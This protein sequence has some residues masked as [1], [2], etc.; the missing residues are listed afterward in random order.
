M[1]LLIVESSEKAKLI[2][3]MLG[4]AWAVEACLGHVRDLPDRELGVDLETL[5]PTYQVSERSART[6]NKLRAQAAKSDHIFLATDKDREGEAIAWH[7]AVLLGIEQPR[8][9]MYTEVTE[10]A[11]RAAIDSPRSIDMPKV[12]AQETRRVLDR[13]VGY[14]LS[15]VVSDVAQRPGLSAG[16]VQSPALCLISDRERAIADF[17]PTPHFS[18]RAHFATPGEDGENTAWFADW[19]PSIHLPPGQ[20]LCLDKALAE[21]VAENNRFTVLSSDTKRTARHAPAPFTTSVLQ[22]VA[23]NKLGFDPKETMQLAQRLYDNGL[24]TY[25]RTD[26]PHLAEEAIDAIR[27]TITGSRY[28]ALLSA[29]P[30]QYKAKT[31]AEE[32]H[33]AIRPTEPSRRKVTLGEKENALYELIWRRALGSQMKPAIYDS[34]T[35]KLQT[36]DAKGM[37]YLFAARG[38]LVVDPGWTTFIAPESSNA[39]GS[40]KPSPDGGAADIQES[41]P[42]AAQADIFTATTTETIPKKTTSPARYSVAA[43]IALLERV[44]IGRPSTYASILET[45]LKRQYVET[46]KKTQLRATKL[47]LAV[48]GLL[49]SNTRIADV[50]YTARMESRLD[51]I[52]NET[53][54][55][56][57]VL[58]QVLQ[59]LDA[60]VTA[61]QNAK[62]ELADFG[63]KLSAV[64]CP[65]C[66]SALRQDFHAR[67]KQHYWRCVGTCG[68][69]APDEAGEPLVLGY[70]KAIT[71]PKCKNATLK[72]YPAMKGRTGRTWLCPDGACRAKFPDVDGEPGSEVVPPK[73]I[74]V[75]CPA[76]NKGQLLARTSNGRT[77]YGCDQFP[78]CNATV[79]DTG[80]VPDI[81]GFH[82]KAAAIAEAPA[83]P[84]CKKGK[85]LQR[86]S[87]R[88][89]PFLGCSRFPKCKHTEPLST[90]SKD[91]G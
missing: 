23:S 2:Q 76:C 27:Q 28:A 47:G 1:N 65:A 89:G 54:S 29:A 40:G 56:K 16:R 75:P 42:R 80:G 13:L 58:L 19:E 33:E 61:L 72:L 46:V 85:L 71:C 91:G 18:V 60:E 37:G 30:Q 41:L 50:N 84:K 8:R 57:S 6:V 5:K 66:G 22:Q 49:Q 63:V 7:L 31:S 70:L 59:D 69:A 81:A 17:T 86:A 83:C 88:N 78:K 51:A 36:A 15:P 35:I 39:D 87:A 90:G 64:P 44:G 52:A 38:R 53:D 79:S 20:P 48:A 82:A 68:F 25:M 24:I 12:R 32:A 67:S 9:V 11:V 3:S 62:V 43:F 26:S 55:Y 45:L 34:T 10:S 21:R 14:L 4:P 77:W 73:T 74:D